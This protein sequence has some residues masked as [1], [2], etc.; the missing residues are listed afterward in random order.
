MGDGVVESSSEVGREVE[1][2]GL[3]ENGAEPVKKR[4]RDASEKEGEK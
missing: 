4:R 2:G 1:G 3:E